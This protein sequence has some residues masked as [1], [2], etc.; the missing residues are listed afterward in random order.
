MLHVLWIHLW[1]STCRP[2]GSQLGS[3][4]VLFHYYLCL[5][6]LVSHFFIKGF[7]ELLDELN[8]TV[9]YYHRFHRMSR[10]GALYLDVNWVSVMEKWT[11]VCLPS[12]VEWE[13]ILHSVASVNSVKRMRTRICDCNISYDHSYPE[14]SILSNQSIAIFADFKMECFLKFMQKKETKEKEIANPTQVGL[15]STGL[16]ENLVF[17]LNTRNMASSF[18]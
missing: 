16:V 15:F 8:S 12:P 18:P 13:V 11:R 10:I 17:V 6:I 4:A 7:V 5:F 1:C 9:T 2:L 14:K 3:R